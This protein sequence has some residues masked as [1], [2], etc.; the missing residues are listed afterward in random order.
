MNL[1]S[2]TLA[3][4]VYKI[5]GSYVGD[6]GK[7]VEFTIEILKADEQ[8]CVAQFNKKSGDAVEFY[9]VVNEYYKEPINKLLTNLSNK[10][11]W[12]RKSVFIDS[13]MFWFIIS[14]L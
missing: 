13:P 6:N 7:K 1:N 14:Y 10:K 8:T 11:E 4:D 3:E 5:K 2:T 12:E 9:K